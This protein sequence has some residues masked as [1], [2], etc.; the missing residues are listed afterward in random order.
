MLL[1]FRQKISY[2][3]ALVALIFAVNLLAA[4][5]NQAT[6]F[7]TGAGLEVSHEEHA[8][9]QHAPIQK[10]HDH[11]KMCGIHTCNF[12]VE[13]DILAFPSQFAETTAFSVIDSRLNGL[14]SSPPKE[15]PKA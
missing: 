2:I 9:S 15:P 12:C 6:A 8:D 4:V 11:V 3:G 1:S 13:E 7:N 5:P 14:L 10:A